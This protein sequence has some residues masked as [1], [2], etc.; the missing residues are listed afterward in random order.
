MPSRVMTNNAERNAAPF[1][2]V[3]LRNNSP[4]PAASYSIKSRFEHHDR[5]LSPSAAHNVRFDVVDVVVI[6]LVSSF[7]YSLFTIINKATIFFK[8]KEKIKPMLLSLNGSSLKRR[9]CRHAPL[10]R[11]DSRYWRAAERASNRCSDRLR[12]ETAPQCRR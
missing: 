6:K 3:A 7:L 1:V 11:V 12:L 9:V 10:R 2:T 4:P 5:H 8:K